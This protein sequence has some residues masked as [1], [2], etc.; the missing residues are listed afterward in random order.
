MKK[1]ILK[2]EILFCQLDELS[3]D[4]Q[5]LVRQAISATNRSYSHYSHFSV[6]ACLRLQNGLE[7]MGPNQENAVY[8]V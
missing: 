2:S 3:A 5:H 7:V 6:G 8:P 4:D 1:L